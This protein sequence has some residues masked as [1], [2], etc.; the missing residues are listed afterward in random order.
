MPINKIIVKGDDVVNPESYRSLWNESFSSFIARLVS[1]VFNPLSLPPVLFGISLLVIGARFP[2]IIGA[3]LIAL[4]FF[5]AIPMVILLYFRSKR[6]IQNFDITNRDERIKPFLITIISYAIG[7]FVFQNWF[8][9]KYFFP[10]YFTICYIINTIIGAVITMKWKISIHAA[11]M[12]TFG[13]I[14]LFLYEYR[15]IH[16]DFSLSHFFLW[17]SLI[18]IPII[19]WSRVRLN[20]HTITQTIAGA[21]IGFIITYL[22][23]IIMVNQKI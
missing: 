22:E 15:L 14:L 18:L 9:Y 4:L 1:D 11:G 12:A 7:F 10:E 8:S 16:N 13:S 3:F 23:L 21:S 17:S 5:T 20:K 19:M 6:Y 2:E